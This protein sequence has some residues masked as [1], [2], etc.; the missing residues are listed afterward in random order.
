MKRTLWVFAGALLFRTFLGAD[1]LG[2]VEQYFSV[3]NFEKGK[4]SRTAQLPCYA[5]V[6]QADGATVEVMRIGTSNLVPFKAKQG[7]S[8]AVCGSVAAFDEGFEAGIPVPA[9][10]AEKR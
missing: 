5:Y 10:P 2:F 3:L 6:A 7:L 4:W 1:T 9:K 8:V